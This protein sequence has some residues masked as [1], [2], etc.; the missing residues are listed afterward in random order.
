M[1]RR[2]RLR[3]ALGREAFV[4][5]APLPALSREIAGAGDN[6]GRTAN[7]NWQRYE[8]AADSAVNATSRVWEFYEPGKFNFIV[9]SRSFAA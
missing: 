6:R 4:P 7:V 8:T 5:P 2:L 9:G 1:R 3:A